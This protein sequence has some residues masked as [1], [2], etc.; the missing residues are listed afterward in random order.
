MKP[1]EHT[2]ALDLSAALELLRDPHTEAIAGG[3]DL[4]GELKRRIRAP[5]RIVNLKTISRLKEIDYDGHLRIGPLATLGEIERHP[6]VLSRFSLLRDALA[7]TS[8]PQLRNMGT[9][10]GNL[11]QRPRCWYYRDSLFH[12]WLKNG[13][14]CFAKEGENRYHAILGG[15][16]C[17]AVHPS[18]LAPA[19]IALNARVRI[20]RTGGE[21]EIPLEKI[22]TLPG[23]D[24]RRMTILRRGELITEISV[25]VPSGNSRGVFLKAMERK[26]WAFALVS[27]AAQIE[28]DGDLIVSSNLILGGVAPIPWRA[29]GAERVLTG[30]KLSGEI[31]GEAAEAAVAQALPLKQNEYKINLTKGLVRQALGSLLRNFKLR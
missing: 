29:D 7:V 25:P 6:E 28:V 30:Q 22:Y 17:Y 12:C 15:R 13:E 2:N 18:D 9:V 20:A 24:H 26:G 16:H 19:L 10:G 8:T 5:R 27:V 14:R 21:E 23:P 11:C 4:L 3:T 31:V 1:F